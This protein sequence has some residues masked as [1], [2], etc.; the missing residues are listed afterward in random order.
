MM[1][2]AFYL[3]RPGLEGL[4][5][6]HFEIGNPGMG[7]SEYEFLLVSQLLH[8]RGKIDCVLLSRT[9]LPPSIHSVFVD[10]IGEAIDYCQKEHIG[11]FVIN[12]GI[13]EKLPDNDIRKSLSL[14][15]WAH[16]DMPEPRMKL[17]CGDK[18][19]KKVVFCG[20]EFM[21]LNYD[22]L[23]MQKSTYVYNI[24]PI[25]SKE[26]YAERMDN[27]EN[28]N[29]V[30]MGAIHWGKGFHLLAKAW[31]EII[32]SVPDAQLY[33]IGSGQLYD[34]NIPLGKFGIAEQDYEDLFMPYLVDK[35][36]EIIPSVHFLGV[37]GEGKNEIMGKCKVGVPNPSGNTECLPITTIE[38]QLM[39][40]SLT[41]IR[42]HAYLDTVYNKDFLYKKPY[43]LAEYVVKRLM[44]EPDDFS[45]VYR[46]ISTRFDSGNSLAR[47]ENLL[48][49]LEINEIEPYSGYAYHCKW[50]KKLLLGIK[51]KN[52]LLSSI[53]PQ[54]ESMYQLYERALNR[55]YRIVR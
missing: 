13:Y 30:Y 3:D 52:P 42:H 6:S 50:M 40:C 19:V 41:T 1:K 49:H 9:M 4:D 48:Q 53:I 39:G 20:R 44:G 5:Y 11:V 26:W 35:D 18:T 43:C 22:N 32:R 47:W 51:L 55:V 21:E 36:G 12:Q 24:F 2:I 34:K 33:V 10:D 8:K 23:I 38:M 29:V 15:L 27:R 45:Q 14:V 37:L 7:G 31:P 17:I 28:H 46:F 54:F 16:N 25:Q